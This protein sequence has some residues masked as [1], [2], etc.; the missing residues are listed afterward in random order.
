MN[1]VG[2]PLGLLF[3]RKMARAS[4][5]VPIRAESPNTFDP[6]SPHTPNEQHPVNEFPVLLISTPTP[7]TPA[8]LGLVVDAFTPSVKPLPAPSPAVTPAANLLELR[9]KPATPEVSPEN[10]CASPS[11]AAELAPELKI[12]PRT[13]SDR[14]VVPVASPKIAVPTLAASA[15]STVP[16][17]QQG[18][19]L[20]VI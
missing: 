13:P 5:A 1:A 4:S 9:L 6:V 2:T 7:R 16:T 10:P 8:P 12:W 15:T 20:S 3:A 14:P 18:T 19:F 11:T 17:A